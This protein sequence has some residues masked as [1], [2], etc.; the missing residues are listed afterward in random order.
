MLKTK[1]VPT[2]SNNSA[3][4]LYYRINE[5]WL[6]LELSVFEKALKFIANKR[7]GLT[8]LTEGDQR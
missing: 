8:I 2:M 7:P 6:S 3:P 4:F 5:F 1:R